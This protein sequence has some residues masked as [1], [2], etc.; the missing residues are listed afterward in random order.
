MKQILLALL[1]LAMVAA[2]YP[3]EP[4]PIAEEPAPE[5]Q[6]TELVA[7]EITWNLNVNLMPEAEF[8]AMITERVQ[9]HTILTEEWARVLTGETGYPYFARTIRNHRLNAASQYLND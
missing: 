7:L 9:F 2:S 5:S 4:A 8:L 6:L 3:V 1:L